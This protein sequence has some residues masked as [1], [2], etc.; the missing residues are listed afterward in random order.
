M[1][2]RPEKIEAAIGDLGIDSI[3]EKNRR[4][5][6]SARFPNEPDYAEA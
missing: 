6:F 5:S 2:S 1:R 4:D 3:N